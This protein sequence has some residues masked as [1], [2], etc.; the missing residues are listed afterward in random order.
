M[1]TDFSLACDPP[2]ARLRLGGEL[3][4]ASLDDLRDLLC[5][6]R[7]RGCDRVQVDADGVTFVDAATLRVLDQEQ[8]GLRAEGG[9]LEVVAASS[10]YLVVSGLAG[11]ED[12]EPFG[13]W[14]PQLTLL[15]GGLDAGPDR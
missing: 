9:S 1:R 4:L 2:L 10:A 13:R 3:D 15:D 6:V 14:P 7:L 12:L 11:Y 5:R 8:R